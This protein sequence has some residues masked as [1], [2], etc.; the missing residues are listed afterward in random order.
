MPLNYNHRTKVGMTDHVENTKQMVR[1]TGDIT[2]TNKAAQRISNADFNMEA[3]MGLDV[4]SAD[5]TY[6]AT[7]F[8]ANGQTFTG[9]HYLIKNAIVDEMTITE[10]GRD[11][12]TKVHKLSRM[13]LSKI[14]T[15]AP[16]PKKKAVRPINVNINNQLPTPTPPQGSAKRAAVKQHLLSYSDLRRLENEFPEQQELILSGV[17]NGW[18]F[19][20]IKNAVKLASL[21]DQLPV[22]PR[23]GG[24]GS[25]DDL[26]VR[27]LSTL[28]KNP[29]KTIEKHYG[30][31][32][33][34]RILNSND[35]FLG[36]KELLVIGANRLG[37]NYTGYS[38]IESM[39]DFI[40]RANSGR[41]NN[42]SGF[43]TFSMPNLFKR[44]T[45]MV[46]EE[47]WKVEDYFAQENCFPTSHNDF[48][49]QMRIRPSGGTMWEG[50]DAQGRVKHGTLG[51][52]NT[53][54]AELDTKAQMLGFNREMIENDD[55]GVIDEIL[56]LMT[57]GAL[58]VPDFKLL[59]HMLAPA[60]NGFWA[61]TATATL[62]KNLY[63]GTAL[64]AANLSTLY[65]AVQ[66]QTIDKG[67]VDWV[68][69]ITDQWDLVIPPELEET[70]WNIIKQDR[71][72]SPVSSDLTTAPRGDK[73]YWFG[74]LGIKKFNQLSNTTMHTSANG[75]RWFLWPKAT[76]YAP[77]AVSYLR[78][79][80]RPIVQVK[81]APVDMLGFVVV[82]VFD[83]NINDREQSAII[84]AEA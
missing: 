21:E 69:M 63:T 15:P 4:E 13:E 32:T 17:D 35:S 72:I 28:C 74:K 60:G 75:T 43:S 78:N 83:I 30:A 53:Y 45:E 40:G 79:R 47:S 80:R 61:S 10:S 81:E 66:K 38:D 48:K 19:S 39:I 18:S 5:V 56:T 41:L 59:Q 26:E 2:E 3:S 31:E 52:E 7:G 84:R 11:V 46:I 77:F 12:M 27:L 68:N 25:A 55:M 42:S 1:G 22:P 54:M 29:E 24:N 58:I 36:L 20:R 50:L 67:R 8:D 6:S 76:R 49:K 70:A 34:D 82:G 14:K 65:L 57:E 37:G 9:P 23:L 16:T 62:K 44:V 71:V 73:N 33:R 64:T 51:K